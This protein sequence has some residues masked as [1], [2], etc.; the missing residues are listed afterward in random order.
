MQACIWKGKQ[1][2]RIDLDVK[3][4]KNSD[5]PFVVRQ[6]PQFQSMIKYYR[7][8]ARLYRTKFGTLRYHWSR[9]LRS[10]P[11]CR[12]LLVVSSVISSRGADPLKSAL[13]S[14][15][16]ESLH[17]HQRVIPFPIFSTMHTVFLTRSCKS[18]LS[19]TVSIVFKR[20]RT[21]VKIETGG[22]N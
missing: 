8:T 16:V 6:H 10:C 20:Y 22:Q 3:D 13:I 15:L 7:P 14:Q 11:R 4:A 21:S 2:K 5:S 18:S 9:I 12:T 17:R 19:V 1:R